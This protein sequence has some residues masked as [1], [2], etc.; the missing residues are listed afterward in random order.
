MC[1]YKFTTRFLSEIVIR[2]PIPPTSFKFDTLVQTHFMGGVGAILGVDT[3]LVMSF[4]LLVNLFIIISSS[5][6]FS[7][8]WKHLRY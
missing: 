6:Q 8:A 2:A 7:Q 3:I 5:H 1:L 4:D